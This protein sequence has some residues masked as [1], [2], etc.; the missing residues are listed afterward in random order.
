MKETCF[1]CAEH[2]LTCYGSGM[3]YCKSHRQI[4]A[5]PDP[6]RATR[7][8]EFN[9]RATEIGA[10]IARLDRIEAQNAEIIS[11]LSCPISKQEEQYNADSDEKR[12]RIGS[13]WQKRYDELKEMFDS[14]E[15]D[16]N[17]TDWN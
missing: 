11:L 1:N 5:A 17:H 6:N 2:N 15:P 3:N 14:D 12:D 16:V 13:D 7:N 8:S 10:L 4:A 9:R